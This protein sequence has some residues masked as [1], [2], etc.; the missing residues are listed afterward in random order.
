MLL[1]LQS[2]KRAVEKF[3]LESQV[4]VFLGILLAFGVPLHFYTKDASAFVY[5]N[6]F[7]GLATFFLPTLVFVWK[8]QWLRENMSAWTYR[9]LWAAVFLA[10][11]FVS[12]LLGITLNGLIIGADPLY[13]TDSYNVNIFHIIGWV[14]A[15]ADLLLHGPLTK[16]WLPNL[17]RWFG[18]ISQAKVAGALLLGSSMILVFSENIL[19]SNVMSAGVMG[20]G[21]LYTWYAAQGVLMFAPFW[22]L[23]YFHQHFLFRQLYPERGL[24]YYI[25]GVVGTVLIFSP[26]YLAAIQNLPIIGTIA[27]RSAEINLFAEMVYAAP[28]AFMLL[29]LPVILF[30]EWM[31]KTRTIAQLQQQQSQTELTLLKEQVNPHFFFNTLN[32]LYSL[33]LQ[34]APETPDTVLQ[35]SEL[36]RYVIYR[37]KEERVALH[38]EIAYLRDYLDLQRIR[39]QENAEIDFVVEVENGALQVPPLLFIILVENAFK[40]GVEKATGECFLQLE[41]RERNG[42]VAVVCRNSVEDNGRDNGMPPGIGLDNL[43]RRLELLYPGA[44]SLKT[45]RTAGEYRVELTFWQ[46]VTL[47]E[48]ELSMDAMPEVLLE[49]QLV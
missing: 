43:T 45:S 40:H 22:G 10:Y 30:L 13:R 24:L 12:Y 6:I 38:E 3:L 39:L 35:L 4:W 27:G 31:R 2:A 47:R 14:F 20:G 18:R 17:G 9:G 36:M 21:L 8:R 23:F 42:E 33:S 19:M 34:S 49:D 5:L 16:R 1:F 7:I 25:A 37:A 29:S 15:G 28:I 46:A 32:N 11:P 48:A 44:H 26:L 41:M